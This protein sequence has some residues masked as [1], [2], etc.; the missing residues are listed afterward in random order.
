MTRTEIS[1]E[2]LDRILALTLAAPREDPDLAPLF[3]IH[4]TL[5]RRARVSDLPAGGSTSVS[6]YDA[7]RRSHVA[8]GGLIS[9]RRVGPF[10]VRLVRWSEDD[11]EAWRVVESSAGDPRVA[12]LTYDS[13]TGPM[14]ERA[15]DAAARYAADATEVDLISDLD[16]DAHFFG[17][18][19]L[20]RS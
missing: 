1:Q 5:C 15:R 20:S 9:T 13:V 16:P 6:I 7:I 10:V 8:L 12:I 18:C 11:R 2:A 4:R 19:R 3:G 14:D 17:Q